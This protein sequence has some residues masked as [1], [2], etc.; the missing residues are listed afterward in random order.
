MDIAKLVSILTLVSLK[1]KQ[2][3]RVFTGIFDEKV[4]LIFTPA[5]RTISKNAKTSFT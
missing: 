1:I 2:N 3:A 5:R 4:A